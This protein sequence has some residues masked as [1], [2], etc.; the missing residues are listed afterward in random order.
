M[1]KVYLSI[2]ASMMLFSCGENHTDD[3]Y[4]LLDEAHQA[5]EKQNFD[6]A[7]RLIDSLRSTYPKE[8]DARR[9]ALAFSDTIE[10]EQAK[11]DYMVADSLFTFKEF[12]LSDMKKQFVFEKQEKYQ[13]T[14]YYVTPDYAGVKSSYNFFPEVEET[15]ALL[16]VSINRSGKLN[17]DF[18]E[19]EIDPSSDVIPPA[20]I[21][22]SLSPKEQ[23]AY[24]KCYKLARCFKQYEVA[25]SSREEYDLKVRFF[26]RKIKE[27]KKL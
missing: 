14:G 1:K 3:A 12:E 20:S 23:N 13:T 8:F 22:R 2:L 6:T 27:Q 16:L 7:R 18:T 10:L 4:A 11:C 19:V 9:A 24:E 17:Y 5:V 15:G 25:K 26:E 21:A